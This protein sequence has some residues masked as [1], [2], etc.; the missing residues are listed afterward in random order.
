MASQVVGRDQIAQVAS[1]SA[2]ENEIGELIAE[3]MEKVGKDG[4]ISVEES[5]GLQYET[6]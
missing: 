3:V 4:V 2:H 1:L 6:E 5:R